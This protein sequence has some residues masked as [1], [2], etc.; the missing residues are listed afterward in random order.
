M[1]CDS[2]IISTSPY[3]VFP[4]VFCLPSF[5]LLTRILLSFFLSIFL[6]FASGVICIIAQSLSLSTVIS[7]LSHLVK[8]STFGLPMNLSSIFMHLFFALTFILSVNAQNTTLSTVTSP[9]TTTS[10]SASAPVPS[11]VVWS[12]KLG[13]L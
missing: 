13:M 10:E 11:Q 6:F 5:N 1:I 8:S 2:F 7:G 12:E 9:T 4:I 3:F